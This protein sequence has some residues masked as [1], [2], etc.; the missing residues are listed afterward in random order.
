MAGFFPPM[1][2]EDVPPSPKPVPVGEPDEPL[3]KA[4]VF[5]AELHA[6]S[7]ASAHEPR[8]QTGAEIRILRSLQTPHADAMA[9][10]A[11]G[12]FAAHV[13]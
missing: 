2:P 8:T 3:S 7:R 12:S 9:V 10:C 6:A 4:A 5:G 11:I 13:V 1:V